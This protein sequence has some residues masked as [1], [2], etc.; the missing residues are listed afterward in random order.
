MAEAEE[1]V[2]GWVYFHPTKRARS[3][4]GGIVRSIEPSGG[5]TARGDP[6]VAIILEARAEARDQRW[7]GK[8]HGMAW[9]GGLV[10]LMLPHEVASA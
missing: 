3:E 8:A 5:V 2:G 1:L 7:R 10:P 6:E 9:T 4:F